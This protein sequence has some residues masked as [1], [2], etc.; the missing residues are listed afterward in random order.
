MNI[1]E[2]SKVFMSG[3]HYNASNHIDAALRKEIHLASVVLWAYF[4]VLL[5]LF[6]LNI[7]ISKFQFEKLTMEL[8]SNPGLETF[9]MEN[10]IQEN[11]QQENEQYG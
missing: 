2:I 1:E 10:V 6:L 9:S 11:Y 3:Y 5:L 7:N 8:K 4:I